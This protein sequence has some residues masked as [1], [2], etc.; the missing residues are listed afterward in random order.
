MNIEK[1]ILWSAAAG[2]LFGIIELFYKKHDAKRNPQKYTKE[3]EPRVK[4][5]FDVI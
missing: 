2:V 4:S 5:F 3:E 1:F